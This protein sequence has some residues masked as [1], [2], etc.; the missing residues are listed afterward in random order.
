MICTWCLVHSLAVV[1][2]TV[3]PVAVSKVAVL[4]VVFAKVASTSIAV[5][6]AATPVVVD[7]EVEVL[8][9]AY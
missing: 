2:A 9:V 1:E 8:P 5:V 7:I 6:I 3:L 4:E